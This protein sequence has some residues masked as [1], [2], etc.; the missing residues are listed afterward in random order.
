M[1]ICN[2]IATHRYVTVLL[3]AE[4]GESVGVVEHC[5][6]RALQGFLVKEDYRWLKVSRSS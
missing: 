6:A 5:S 1:D 2:Q 3:N 4:T